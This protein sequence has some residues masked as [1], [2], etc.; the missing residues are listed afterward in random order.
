[1][2]LDVA[3][4]QAPSVIDVGST[5]R[6]SSGTGVGA[7]RPG[8]QVVRG[9]PGSGVGDPDADSID[10]R[11]RSAVGASGLTAVLHLDPERHG[12]SPPPPG[13]S[14]VSDARE[15]RHV[16][17]RWPRLRSRRTVS[18]V[19]EPVCEV[20]VAPAN[21]TIVVLGVEG[22]LSLL[23]VMRP[24]SLNV[25][26][27]VEAANACTGSTHLTAEGSPHDLCHALIGILGWIARNASPGNAATG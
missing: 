15:A 13:R 7:T 21:E 23:P 19:A 25:I 22:A 18:W 10:V 17:R 1:M 8:C 3:A 16:C 27:I 6:L 11:R 5:G 9:F 12:Q 26:E 2:N 4:D 14:I 24:R 20:S